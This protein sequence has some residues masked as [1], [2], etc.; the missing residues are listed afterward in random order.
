MSLL[1][2]YPVALDRNDKQT[3]ETFSSL[4]IGIAAVSLIVGGIGMMNIMLVSVTERTREIGIRKAIGA[5]RVAILLQFMVEAIALC[6]L[7]GGLG[8]AAGYAGAQ[9]MSEQAGW[10]T[11]VTPDSMALGLLVSAVVGLFFGIVPAV[12]ASYLDPVEALRYD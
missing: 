7:G 10:M 2:R 5:T 6:L 11:I 8:C 4:V 3:S 9:I 1:L 12:R